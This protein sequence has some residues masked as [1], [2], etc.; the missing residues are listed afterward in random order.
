[1]FKSIKIKI[2]INSFLSL[3]LFI[4]F[5]VVLFIARIFILLLYLY[6]QSNQ[7]K[8]IFPI[9]LYITDAPISPNI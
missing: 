3:F 5:H 9:I 1:M 8:Y 2:H 6:I 4:T 7:V